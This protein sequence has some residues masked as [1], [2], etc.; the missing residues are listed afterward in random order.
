[1][2]FLD[3]RPLEVICQMEEYGLLDKEQMKSEVKIFYTTVDKIMKI[4]LPEKAEKYEFVYYNGRLLKVC[5]I[6]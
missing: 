6:N 3:A 1:M 2:Y 4:L 5:K